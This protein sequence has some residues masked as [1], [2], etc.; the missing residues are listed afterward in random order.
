MKPVKRLFIDLETSYSKV[1]SFSLWPKYIP[2]ENILEEWYILCACWKWEGKKT[3]YGKKSK[4]R[5]DKEVV[6][7]ISDAVIK[8]DEIVYHNGRKFD[9]K[10]LNTRVL[11]NG[12]PPIPKPRECDTLLQARKHFGFT[13]NRLDYIGQILGVGGKIHTDNGL[14]LRCLKGD[15]QALNEMYKYNKRDVTL[16]EDVYQK[17][18]PH[19]DVSFNTNVNKDLGLNCPSCDSFNYQKRGWV[20]TLACKYQRYQCQDCGKWFKDGRRKKRGCIPHR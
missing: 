16:L 12:L 8:A 9:W 17:M 11:L 2:H 18:K 4:D 10:K 1:A 7:A 5:C 20:T 19:I 6:K 3:V 15:K 14:W 13:S